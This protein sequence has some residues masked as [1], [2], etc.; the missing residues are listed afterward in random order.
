MHKPSVF[1][2]PGMACFDKWIA[3]D[4]EERLD[5]WRIHLN[6]STATR[7]WGVIITYLKNS[8]LHVEVDQKQSKQDPRFEQEVMPRLEQFKIDAAHHIMVEGIVVAVILK[9]RAGFFVPYV[10][11]YDSYSLSV[12]YSMISERIE[13]KVE[14]TGDWRPSPED[15]YTQEPVL[16]G[17]VQVRS[18]LGRNFPEI[19]D[20][21]PTVV[22]YDDFD[23][24]P[25]AST[26]ALTSM[27]ARYYQ[28]WKDLEK[29]KS[30]QLLHLERQVAPTYYLECA[31]DSDA[32]RVAEMWEPDRYGDVTGENGQ[33][34]LEARLAEQRERR[35]KNRV[36]QINTLNQKATGLL[37]D[38]TTS[39]ESSWTTTVRGLAREGIK[40][41]P[42]GTKISSMQRPTPDFDMETR[43]A[44]AQTAVFEAY[45]VPMA[46]FKDTMRM[47]SDK[48]LYLDRLKDAV[49]S[50]AIS[51]TGKLLTPIYNDLYWELTSAALALSIYKDLLVPEM[52]QYLLEDI[53]SP[54]FDREADGA[55]GGSGGTFLTSGRM[56]RGRL[57]PSAGSKRARNDRSSLASRK[58]KRLE[59]V[60]DYPT[61]I[62]Q[63]RQFAQETI[64]ADMTAFVKKRPDKAE[65][66]QGKAR[67][68]AR[69]VSE[70][71]YTLRMDEY[72]NERSTTELATD[73][74]MGALTSEEFLT[75]VRFNNG[76]KQ[77]KLEES[78]MKKRAQ[79]LDKARDKNFEDFMENLF[80][81][82]M[83]EID[84]A[85]S[86][87]PKKP[88]SSEAGPAKK[89][90]AA[91][92]KKSQ[93]QQQQKTKDTGTEKGG[94][95]KGKAKAKSDKKEP[96]K[97]K[98]KSKSKSAD[99]GREKGGSAKGED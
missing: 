63:L 78:V 75:K 1:F 50:F 22:I 80:A 61:T 52:Q 60:A 54:E 35:Y 24:K 72:A 85:R 3:V 73:F 59:S 21:D 13:Y 94:V 83:R 48:S 42:E 96:S 99:A 84:G 39:R 32:S 51:L 92:P 34:R 7:A 91:G 31:P 79:A 19:G 57:T 90:E 38:A 88:A 12:Q 27:V 36:N 56:N 15:I 65:W 77:E 30:L 46:L 28:E 14:R 86:G 9:T 4:Q 37:R 74:F 68:L 33:D 2:A 97:D 40:T 47:A 70:T 49:D 23:F 87:G 55:G 93:Q 17:L 18:D 8:L 45:G 71:K 95:D 6:E 41:L 26:G 5:M 29:V 11:P 58:K 10:L 53:E 20:G 66:A 81:S 43:I 67:D 44:D 25:E 69:R 89:K 16:Q 62:E 64:E 82:S 98:S 76:L